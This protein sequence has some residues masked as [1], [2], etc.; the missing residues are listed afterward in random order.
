MMRAAPLPFIERALQR[1]RR[2]LAGL[3][4]EAD[5]LDAAAEEFG[6]AAFVGGDVRLV[7]AQ[8]GAPRRREV[9]QR[10]RVC[11]RAGRHQEHRDLALKNLGESS[12]DPLG[13]IIAAVGERGA[14]VRP[15][16]GRED[17]RRDPGCVVACKVHGVLSADRRDGAAAPCDG[18]APGKRSAAGKVAIAPVDGADQGV[19]GDG[20]GTQ[21]HQHQQ[22]DTQ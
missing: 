14:V 4:C 13:P 10:E 21:Q 3:A 18:Q 17:L 16:N 5:E 22:I 1:R 12:L 19:D 11:R 2:D 15:G 8:H 9:C 7:V 6:R 20:A